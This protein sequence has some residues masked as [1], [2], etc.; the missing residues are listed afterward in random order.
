MF[1][2]LCHQLAGTAGSTAAVGG[3]DSEERT[4]SALIAWLGSE[5]VDR[6]ELES[7]LAALARD[8]SDDLNAKIDKAAMLAAAAAGLCQFN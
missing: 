5:Y 2:V 4:R 7:R 8:V 1:I 3:K 6:S